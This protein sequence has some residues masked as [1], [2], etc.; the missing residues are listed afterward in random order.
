MRHN[1]I[2]SKPGLSPGWF[3]FGV[4]PMVPFIAGSCLLQMITPADVFSGP[5]FALKSSVQSSG[6]HLAFLNLGDRLVFVAAAMLQVITCIGVLVIH[7][8]RIKMMPFLVRRRVIRTFLVSVGL[9]M[10]VCIWLRLQEAAVYELTFKM[11]R[12]LLLASH[13]WAESFAA[14]GFF[15]HQS[16]IFWL[17]FIPFVLGA[18][19]VALVP[20]WASA[21]VAMDDIA[22]PDWEPR[23]TRRV[24]L[25]QRSFRMS[26]LVLVTSAI[27]LMLFVK[28]PLR[29]MDEKGTDAFSH[30]AMGL[31][32]FWGSV[33][34]LTLLVAFAPM[35]YCLSR[36]A[37]MYHSKLDTEQ[38][39]GG[40]VAERQNL[41]IKRNLTNLATVLAPVMVGP[42]GG[43]FQTAL[44]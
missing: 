26:S 41:S 16:R 18:M 29:L 30:I 13:G 23:F 33:M 27:A 35:V 20:A 14:S 10:A 31:P 24:L 19:T 6:S 44:G 37:M 43:L 2:Q 32:I 25:L 5:W 40:W 8:R 12:E 36:E 38:S 42:I 28:L 34:T 1:T 22:D 39:F 17:A 9:A 15:L 11:I 7:A 3:W 4:L 21:V